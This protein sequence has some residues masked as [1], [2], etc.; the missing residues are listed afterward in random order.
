MFHGV[1]RQVRLQPQVI[2]NVVNYTVIVDARNQEGKLLPG[3]TA[4]IDFYVEEKKNVLLVPN[5]ALRFQPGP[6]LIA[7]MRE[8]MRRQAESEPDSARAGRSRRMEGGGAFGQMENSG[9]VWYLNAE[10]K[11]E[12]ARMQLGTSDGQFTQVVSSG[13]LQEGMRVIIGSTQEAQAV[14][15]RNTNPLSGGRP[16]GRPPF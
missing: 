3:M 5:S 9:R 10:G 12:V 15:V 7:E 14:R 13:R 6:D 11:P 4:T 8:R 16:P 1:V 2:Q